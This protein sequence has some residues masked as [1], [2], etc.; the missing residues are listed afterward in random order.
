[1]S[2]HVPLFMQPAIS[3]SA[4]DYSGQEFRQ[5]VRSQ[6]TLTTGVGGEQG[7]LTAS[8]LTPSQRAAGANLSIDVAGGFGYVVG[9][10]ATNQGT[11]Q[12]WNDGVF[13]V[14]GWTVP[15]AGTFHHRLV[16]Q[17]EDKLNN[18]VYPGYTAVFLPVLDTGSGLP[19]E[20]NSAITLATVDIPAGSASITNAMINDYRQRIGPVS[21]VRTSDLSRTHATSLTDDPVLQLL[22]LQANAQYAFFG[23]MQ[24]LG[25]SGS[26][27]G[28][29]SWTFR[30]SSGT[31]MSY[32]AIRDN[33]SGT[34]TGAFGFTQSDTPSAQTLGTSQLMAATLQGSIFTGAAPAYVVLQ[35]AQNTD[36]GTATTMKSGSWLRA[37]R[38]S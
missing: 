25:G 2:L 4:I 1:V 19:A 38:L 11:Y 36:T 31:T 7:I 18:G 16:L 3:D 21:A 29:L 13:N 33:A 30:Q 26:G 20:P 37:M 27:E 17:I 10:D 23:N 32:S 34:F 8:N 6:L 9:D 12:C 24:Y 22:N 35:W 14:T 15:G 28:D 5:Y